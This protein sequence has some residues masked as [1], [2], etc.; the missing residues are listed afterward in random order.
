MAT[1][2][3]TGTYMAFSNPPHC[4]VH[5]PHQWRINNLGSYAIEG[6]ILYGTVVS[7]PRSYLVRKTA[8][9]VGAATTNRAFDVVTLPSSLSHAT[10]CQQFGQTLFSALEGGQMGIFH[11]DWNHKR[12]RKLALPEPCHLFS[13]FVFYA[14]VLHVFQPGLWTSL[15]YDL[16]QF[17]AQTQ[18][19]KRRSR[20][21]LAGAVAAHA[22]TVNGADSAVCD[23]ESDDDSDDENDHGLRLSPMRSPPKYGRARARSSFGS[24]SESLSQSSVSDEI[25]IC[26]PVTQRSGALPCHE[27]TLSQACL[28]LLADPPGCIIGGSTGVM[29]DLRTQVVRPL[30][31]DAQL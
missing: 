21:A 10:I 3:S 29:I 20:L 6:P 14:S 1:Y 23:S 18:T 5:G 7:S 8:E 28:S 25:S 9:L 16:G 4:I 11:L 22:N 12:I 30:S 19:P 13:S 17:R 27:A 31:F 15:G 26:D 2:T 24:F